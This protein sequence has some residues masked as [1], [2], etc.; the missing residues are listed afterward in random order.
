VVEVNNMKTRSQLFSSLILLCL[1][2]DVEQVTP[3]SQG[4]GGD[5]G[6]GKQ[7]DAGASTPAKLH[8]FYVVES[9][10]KSVNVS[11]FD[12]KGDLLSTSL[13]TSGS[14]AAGLSAAFSGD[15]VPPSSELDGNEVVLVDRTNTTLN[16]VDLKTTEVR[17]QI[18]VGP[19]FKANPQDYVPYSA[20]RAFV[21]RFQVNAAAGAEEFDAGGDILVVDPT[22]GKLV[23]AIDLHAAFEPAIV[24]P[25]P[26]RALMAGGLLRV[27]AIGMDDSFAYAPGRLI[28]IDPETLQIVDVQVFTGLENCTNLAVSPNGEK[29][30]LACTGGYPDGL[31]HS[32][33]VVLSTEESPV[34]ERQIPAAELGGHT[35]NS[36]HFTND[37][38]LAYTTF[39][40]FPA[41]D[42]EELPV[43]DTLRLLDL[44]S[45]TADAEPVASSTAPFSLAEIRCIQ[46]TS[47]CIAADA[48]FGS[49]SVRRFEI[50]AD[51]RLSERAPITAKD[52]GLL[53]PPRYIGVY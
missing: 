5:A 6:K 30:A 7:S 41:P 34:I 29:L 25:T 51:G 43:V 23:G 49:E 46:E 14:E 52:D 11:V 17:Q 50:E 40:S 38:I 53:L 12:S 15:V 39:G 35:I 2:C 21:P 44:T 19:G 1:G 48:S 8:G 16:W 45:G 42:S 27:T 36:V 4:I 37:S 33:I 24:N 10:Y 47:T 32:G 20:N 9:D 31:S 13:V 18:N 28:S 26:N 3:T 22:L